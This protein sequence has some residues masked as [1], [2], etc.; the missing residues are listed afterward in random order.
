MYTIDDEII[1]N[2]FISDTYNAYDISKI[3]LKEKYPQFDWDTIDLENL[4]TDD[5]CKNDIIGYIQDK[6]NIKLYGI[7]CEKCSQN[8]KLN[9][10][11]IYFS[12]K[13]NLVKGK[14]P[15]NCSK[16][17]FY[18]KYQNIFLINE[19]AK[20]LNYIFCGFVDEYKGKNK[21]KIKLYCPNNKHGIW[22]TTLI[23]SFIE[24]NNG[25]IKCAHESVGLSNSITF[26][27]HIKDFLSTGKYN[28]NT[29]FWKSNK[30]D[31]RGYNNYWFCQCPICKTTVEASTTNLKS[32]KVSCLCNGNTQQ[33][34]YINLVLDNDIPIALKYGITS[35]T[36]VR[37]KTQNRNSIY[38]IVNCGVWEFESSLLCKSAEAECKRTFSPV[39]E[40]REMKDGYTE[41]TSPLDIDKIIEI[42]ENWGGVR[43]K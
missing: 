41:T 25:C 10:L 28:K 3:I 7:K 9:G 13:G 2:K 18:T 40:A 5:Y 31:S 1:N 12:Y 42:Y 36:E 21:T 11:G 37:E 23:Y 19:K 33:Q 6:K 17:K 27:D 26:A 16:H 20:T 43:I 24:S 39:L 14:C 4:K 22:D 15:C 30:I 32:G 34:G 8:Y 29:K 38:D 35:N